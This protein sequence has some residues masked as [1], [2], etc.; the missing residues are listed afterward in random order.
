MLPSTGAYNTCAVTPAIVVPPPPPPPPPAAATN[1][2]SMLAICAALN[3]SYGAF[4][5]SAN[6][7]RNPTS[8]VDG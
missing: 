3:V 7:S 1:A 2:A 6:S 4:P 8:V 5:I